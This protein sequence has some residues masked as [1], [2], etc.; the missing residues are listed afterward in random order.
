MTAVLF[1]F[2]V[3]ATTG[4][5]LVGLGVSSIVP[6]VYSAAARSSKVSPG[7]A[8]AGVS[9]IGFLGFLLGPPIIGYIAQIAGLQYS[10]AVVAIAGLCITAIVSK[11]KVLSG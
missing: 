9:S 11:L 8:L 3:T 1:P 6:T 2:I 5:I 4:F 10:F 7:M